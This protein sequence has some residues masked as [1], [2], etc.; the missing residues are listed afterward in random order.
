MSR[1]LTQRGVDEVVERQAGVD[2]VLGDEHVAPDRRVEVLDQ[3]NRRVAAER[4]V[5]GQGD[6]LERVR[7]AIARERSA[8]KMNAP[9]KTETSTRSRS[10]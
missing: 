8:T 5:A 7:K 1:G 4:A 2:D 10:S 9:R 3:A 6:E